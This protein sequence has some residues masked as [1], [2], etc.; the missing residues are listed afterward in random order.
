MS[1]FLKISM[2]SLVLVVVAGLDA[3]SAVA[4]TTVEPSGAP[5]NTTP[6]TTVDASRSDPAARNVGPESTVGNG[7]TNDLGNADSGLASVPG[8][9]STNGDGSTGG[10]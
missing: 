1:R 2:S 7:R 6:R 3:P 8:A 5:I 9:P 10:H 4:Q